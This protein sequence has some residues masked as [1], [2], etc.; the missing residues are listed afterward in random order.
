MPA[1]TQTATGLDIDNDPVMR[2]RRPL[3]RRNAHLRRRSLAHRAPHPGAHRGL[4]VLLLRAGEGAVL[5]R[6]PLQRKHRPMGSSRRR[7]GADGAEPRARKHASR[8]HDGLSGPR[9]LD[10]DWRGAAESQANA[11]DGRLARSSR[12]TRVRL[13]ADRDYPAFVRI[14]E[15]HTST[16]N[17]AVVTAKHRSGIR[18]RGQLGRLRARY[19]VTPRTLNPLSAKIVSPVTARDQSDARKTATFPT[20]S[21]VML[22]RNGAFSTMRSRACET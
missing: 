13:F 12:V 10:D 17:H 18:D 1:R 9:P 3:R 14:K 15:I 2:C 20:S 21:W 5:G 11:R 8:E 6:R 22:R 19:S 16:A 7:P 4:D